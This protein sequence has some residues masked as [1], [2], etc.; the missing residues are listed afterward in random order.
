[1]RNLSA[2]LLERALAFA[3]NAHAG[4]LEKNG[5]PYIMHPLRLMLSMDTDEEQ[6]AALL[7]D[8]VEDGDGVTFDDLSELGLPEAVLGALRNLTH[9]D[10]EPYEDYIARIAGHPLARKVK[11]A[12]LRDN[13]DVRRL[14][15]FT[16]KDAERMQRYVRAYDILV[17]S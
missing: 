13:M 14:P 9:D 4:Q 7:H 8:V 17:R 11:L 5:H 15:E 12:D 16:E 3:L 2:D 1:M 6:L 10:N